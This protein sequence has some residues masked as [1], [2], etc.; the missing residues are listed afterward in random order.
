MFEHCKNC[1][2][3]LFRAQKFCRACGAPIVTRDDEDAP[4]QIM[5]PAPDMWGAQGAQTAPVSQPETN[6]TFVPPAYYQPSVPPAPPAP[7]MRQESAPPPA[8]SRSP[9]IVVVV[10]IALLM[11]G[12]AIIG[13]RIL[14][15]KV[16]AF[17]SSMMGSEI[18][19]P[20]Q[21]IALNPGAA[22]SIT[23]VNGN[24][25]LEGWDKPQAEIRVTKRGRSE[26]TLREMT[27]GIDASN[28]NN[29][30]IDASDLPDNTSVSFR[31]KV[32]RELGAIKISTTNGRISLSNISGL[33]DAETVN[34]T[35]RF[36]DVSGV[37]RAQ[38]ISGN[39][40][41]SIKALA[42][43]RPISFKTVSGGID[44]RIL[45][46]IKT[47]LS[48][49]TTSGNIEVGLPSPLNARIEASS[50][51]GRVDLDQ[52]GIPVQRET[53]GQ[54]ASGQVGTGGPAVKATTMSGRIEIKTT[55][56]PT[57][58]EGDSNGD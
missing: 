56:A 49:A 53:P 51:S 38:T 26:K 32:P 13:G 36:E 52:L 54:H 39:I 35:I 1:G 8:R 46:E 14:V 4:T 34:G 16:R 27:V 7:P 23:G 33:I 10:L 15:S 22:I 44:V 6:P 17:I 29:L 24:V 28:P 21:M 31:I 18:V 37:A 3:E 41:G 25:T 5:P 30:V 42:Q 19:E 9:W 20:P 50:T 2:A 11:F 47:D 55:N 45:S 48:F 12:G 58:R 40:D 57:G 43:D